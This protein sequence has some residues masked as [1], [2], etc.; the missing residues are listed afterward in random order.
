MNPLQLL[1]VKK[2]WDEFCGR[3]PKFPAFLSAIM[4]GAI[5]EGSVLEMTVTTAEGKTISTN[6]KISVEDMELFAQLKNLS[7]GE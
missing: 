6:M 2:Y 4:K 1:Q 5:K 3:H 7:S